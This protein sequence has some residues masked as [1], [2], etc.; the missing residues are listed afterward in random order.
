VTAQSPAAV[1]ECMVETSFE[2]CPTHTHTQKQTLSAA[3]HRALLFNVVDNQAHV[4]WC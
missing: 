2:S 3:M 1:C 4:L